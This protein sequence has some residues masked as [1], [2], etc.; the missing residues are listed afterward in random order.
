MPKHSLMR[1]PP[2]SPAGVPNETANSAFTLLEML[3]VIGLIGIL[4]AVVVVNANALFAGLGD[5]AVPETLRRAVREARYQAAAMKSE[6]VLSYNTESGRF[7][8]SGSAGEILK[9][10]PVEENP[11][12]VT[13]TFRRLQPGKGD[14]LALNRNPIRREVAA[15]RFHPDRSAT[16]F[17]VDL[18][19]GGGQTVHRYD[20]FSAI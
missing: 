16:L 3:I 20:P 8:I 7:Q 5:E 14:S 11:D 19:H 15:V 4:S 1:H 2:Y 6:T 18:R 13:V 17:E 12:G 9:E 10:L